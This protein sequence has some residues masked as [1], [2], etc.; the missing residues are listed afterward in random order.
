MFERILVCQD[1]SAVARRASDMAL[2]LASR[3][4]SHLVGLFVAD[5]R[6]VEGPAIETLAPM[7]GEI[8]AAPF[9]PEVLRAFQSRGEKEL[10]RFAERAAALGLNA[11][12]IMVEIGV[13][14]E[15]IVE[16][17]AAADLVVL[18]RRGENER[19]GQESIG[20]T[21]ARVVRR[22]PHPVLVAGSSAALPDQ[23]LVAYDG[24]EAAVH[25]LDLAVQYAGAT[26]AALKLVFA[27][28]P[29]TDSVLSR[30]EAMA[31]DHGIH[32]E[33]VHIDAEPTEAIS[34]ASESWSCGC[35]FMG[36][37]GH[38]RI[39]DLFFGS[40]TVAILES[41]ALPVFLTR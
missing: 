32:Y 26:D 35:L 25:A 23:P 40:Q 4:S 36:A 6:V 27:G 9:Q 38:G 3:F 14:E 19:F 11:P 12:D 20:S 24:S 7:W 29:L 41:T 16:Q 15:V 8:S 2:Q 34:R 1:G 31:A 13:A 37:F 33:A 21:A 28:P 39:H 22:S 18:G 30:A 5:V 10:I 17:A